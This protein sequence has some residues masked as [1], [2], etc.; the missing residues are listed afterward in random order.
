VTRLE[1]LGQIAAAWAAARTEE[2]R[3]RRLRA[4]CECE[5]AQP[6][7]FYSDGDKPTLRHSLIMACWKREMWESD[8]TPAV[9]KRWCAP[10]LERQRLHV[11]VL[12]ATR[13]RAALQAGL[14]RSATVPP[15]IARTLEVTL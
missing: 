8:Y 9:P 15:E 12:A 5:R 7:G 10:C 6:E 13:R 3:L 14:M 1:R 2:Q 4:A 11:L